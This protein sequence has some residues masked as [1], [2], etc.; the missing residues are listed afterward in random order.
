M[1][2]QIRFFATR[3][4]LVPVLEAIEKE[5][6]LKYVQFGWS[7][8]QAA[9]S[10]PTLTAI[11]NLGTASHESAIN[12]SSFLICRKQDAIKPRTVPGRYV[13]DQLLNPETV[14][15]TP[16]GLWGDGILLYGRFAT[17]STSV[18]SLELMKLCGMAV[19]K[20]FK[21]VKAFYVGEEAEQLLDRGRRLTIAAQSPRTLDLSRT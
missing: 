16:G 15:F 1:P 4:D 11:P 18:F 6:D 2:T 5:R 10:F 9:T 7:D 14:T 17:A 12:C 21:K 19:R 8:T 13:F 20:R 3:S